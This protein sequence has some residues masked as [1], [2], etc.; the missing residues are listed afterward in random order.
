MIWQLL[1]AYTGKLRLFGCL[2]DDNLLSKEITTAD[3]STSAGLTTAISTI[4]HSEWIQLVG[5]KEWSLPGEDELSQSSSGPAQDVCQTPVIIVAEFRNSRRN[6]ASCGATSH[7]WRA[8]LQRNVFIWRTFFL[9]LV[10]Q[11]NVRVYICTIWYLCGGVLIREIAESGKARQ[12]WTSGHR[13]VADDRVDILCE[14]SISPSL[15]EPAEILRHLL[16]IPVVSDYRCHESLRCECCHDSPS[17]VQ[18]AVYLENYALMIRVYDLGNGDHSS[19]DILCEDR[20]RNISVVIEAAAKEYSGQR[21][22]LSGRTFVPV[23]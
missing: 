23:D 11:Q 17:Q 18:I 7:F 13:L 3:I 21:N 14:T 6:V 9:G 22:G 8:M 5:M 1:F 19:W 12:V 15:G 2:W 20:S 16:E 10:A 4:T